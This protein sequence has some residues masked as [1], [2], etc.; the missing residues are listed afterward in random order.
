MRKVRFYY[1]GRVVGSKVEEIVQFDDDTD[2]AEINE[3]FEMWLY[4]M[5]EA[6]WSDVE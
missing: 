2:D 4:G 5:S 3:A 6:N 1:T